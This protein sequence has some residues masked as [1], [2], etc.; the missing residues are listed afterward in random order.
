MARSALRLSASGRLAVS[1]VASSRLAA[2]RTIRNSSP[3]IR[4]AT[5]V[6]REQSA[7][8]QSARPF[9]APSHI[10]VPELIVGPF[11]VVHV[12]QDEGQPRCP[13]RE[14]A[15]PRGQSFPSESDGSG[16]QSA[17]PALP[18][19]SLHASLRASV[20]KDGG[21]V[22]RR[23]ALGETLQVSVANLERADLLGLRVDLRYSQC[24]DIPEGS[25]RRRDPRTRWTEM[26]FLCVCGRSSALL[27]RHS[28]TRTS[29]RPS[30]TRCS[31]ADHLRLACSFHPSFG[32]RV[33]GR[34]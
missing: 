4:P 26:R 14:R 24:P 32:V 28:R 16:G 18:S 7:W 3:P 12:E 34:I 11:E 8:M 1:S 19:A 21:G 20:V 27:P 15:R 25:E 9:K 6:G 29:S 13:R 10:D 23:E 31:M 17:S 2:G 22:P 30:A 33:P 5:P